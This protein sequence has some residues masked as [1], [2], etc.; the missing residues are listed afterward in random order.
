[1]AAAKQITYVISETLSLDS[2]SRLSPV[3]LYAYGQGRLLGVYK[4]F[5]EAVN[6]AYEEMGMVTDKYQ[7][8]LW[9]RV[10]RGSAITIRDPHRAAYE[11]IRN[12]GTFTEE[13][14]TDNSIMLLDA[15][16]CSLNQ[17]LY[18]IGQE[19][20]VLAYTDNDSYVLLNGFD[21]YNVSI[22]YPET[23]QSVKM[24]LN[25]G[26]EYFESRKNDFICAVKVGD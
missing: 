5:E 6:R 7:R 26:R 1:M 12:L 15:R 9:N 21:Q 8:I 2:E 13:M 22:F 24:G 25:D 14:V 23:G 10:D 18:F 16:G 11:I 4:E 19:I 20:P 17:V 3:E